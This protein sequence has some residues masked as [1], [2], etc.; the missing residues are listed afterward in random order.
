MRNGLATTEYL[1]LNH[2]N[3]H[4]LEAIMRRG[5]KPDVDALAGWEYRGMNIAFWAGILPIKKFIKGFYQDDAGATYGYNEPLVQNPL[6]EPWIAKPNDADPKRFGF[7]LVTPPDAAAKDNLY[8]NSLLLDYGRGKNPIADPSRGLRDYIVRV[9]KGSDDLL[10]G[11][12]F[13]ALGPLRL[14]TFSYFVLEKHRPTD[15][16]R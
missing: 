7:F 3:A 10:L 11:K 13:Y 14:K 15:F 16:V 8:L 4:D 5:E 2:R 6:D 12:A 9:Q 1:A